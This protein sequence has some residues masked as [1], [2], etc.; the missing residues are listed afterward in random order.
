MKITSLLIILLLSCLTAFAGML[1][2][3][4]RYRFRFSDF[5]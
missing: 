2:G 1:S 5:N 4:V 3:D